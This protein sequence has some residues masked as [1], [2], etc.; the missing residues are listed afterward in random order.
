MKECHFIEVSPVWEHLLTNATKVRMMTEEV[1]HLMTNHAYP[2]TT[3]TEE[4]L[5]QDYNDAEASKVNIVSKPN[6]NPDTETTLSD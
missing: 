4:Q 3:L 2:E 1:Y 5:R 6:H